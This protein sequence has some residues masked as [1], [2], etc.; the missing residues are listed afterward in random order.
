MTIDPSAAPASKRA[1]PPRRRIHSRAPGVECPAGSKIGTVALDVPGLPPE[2]LQGNLYLGGPESGPDHGTAVQHVHRRRVPRYGI[3]VRLKGTVVPNEATGQVTARL[4]RK[5]GTA[6]QRSGPALQGRAARRRWPTR[7]TCV[8]ASAETSLRPYTGTAARKTP[9]SSFLV[10]SN[11]SGGAC[12][13]PLPFCARA[14]HL[15]P[16]HEPRG[17][18]PPTRSPSP[19]HGP[20]VPLAGQDRAAGGSGRADPRGDDSSEAQVAEAQTKAEAC[21]ASCQ[22]RD[23]HGLRRSRPRAIPVH[24]LGLPDRPLQRRPLRDGDRRARGRRTVQ[25][26][27]R[28]HARH[29][30]RRTVR[31]DRVVVTSAIPTIVQGRAAADCRRCASKSTARAS[32]STRPTAATLATEST[33]TGFA[34]LGSSTTTTQSLSSPFAAERM[35]QAGVQN[36]PDRLHRLENLESQRGQPRSED[37]PGRRSGQHPEGHHRNCPS[38]C[39]RV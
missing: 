9:F 38:S 5:P 16:A 31:P 18:T 35:Q 17:P 32:C 39:P 24:R 27:Q 6:F 1:R 15:Q 29:D 34:A 25:P 22:H 28:G 20:A 13:A 37:Q 7:S 23:R 10:D 14:E 26:R 11:G 21:P 2:S 3:S 33:L 8:D 30:Q 36:Q 4:H 19:T 12:A